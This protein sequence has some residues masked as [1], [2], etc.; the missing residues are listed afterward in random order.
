M[1]ILCLV[2]G[3]TGLESFIFNSLLYQFMKLIYNY[4]GVGSEDL[5]Q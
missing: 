5:G 1:I 2:C 3:N 4:I